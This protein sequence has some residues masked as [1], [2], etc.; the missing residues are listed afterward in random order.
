MEK[1]F[2]PFRKN[3]IGYDM[4][5]D[6]PYGNV[7]LI[8]ADWI[9]SGRLYRPIEGKISDM[10]GP[11]IGNTHTETSETGTLMTQA[12]HLAHKMIKQHVHAGPDDV[13]ITSGFGMTSAISKLH[14]ILGMKSC[15]LADKYGCVPEQNRPVVFITHMEHHSNHTSW[16]ETT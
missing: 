15:G 13:I 7:P 14:R 5:F 1:Y 16:F 12:Y 10:M 9:A 11:F 6:T 4:T 8:Y 2:S 3:T